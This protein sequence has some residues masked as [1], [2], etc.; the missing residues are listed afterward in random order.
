MGISSLIKCFLLLCFLTFSCTRI[1][2]DNRQQEQKSQQATT[3]PPLQKESS[4]NKYDKVGFDHPIDESKY[5][6]VK[7][8]VD[9]DTYWID[10]GTPTGV[11]IRMLGV[12][13]PESKNRWKNKKEPF[14]KEA[15]DYMK[16]LIMDKEIRL[17]LDVVRYGRYKRT[18]AYGFLKDGTNINIALVKNG[19]AELYTA[20]PNIKYVDDF[21][22]ALKY[23]HDNKSGMWSEQSN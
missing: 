2:S 12:D 10:D 4:T 1:G 8:V 23:A 3:K 17:E 22:K 19:F 21:V 7:K 16:S 14:G 6:Q 20:P 5:Y 9:G 13:A 15:S 18:L 11:K